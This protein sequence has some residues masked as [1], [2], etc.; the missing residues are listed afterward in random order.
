VAVHQRLVSLAM[1]SFSPSEFRSQAF[2]SA[3]SRSLISSLSSSLWLF[4]GG[5]LRSLESWLNQIFGAFFSAA[6]AQVPIGTL[7]GESQVIITPFSGRSSR[8]RIDQGPFSA[9]L[10]YTS[11]KR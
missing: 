9:T 6:T 11:N 5:L 2:I 4:R 1:A 10:C 3:C 7:A 8:F